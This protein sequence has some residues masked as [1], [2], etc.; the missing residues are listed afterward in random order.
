MNL[1]TLFNA[2]PQ[3]EILE[4][5]FRELFDETINTSFLSFLQSAIL[6]LQKE[7]SALSVTADTSAEEFRLKF[8]K[9]QARQFAFEELVSLIETIRQGAMK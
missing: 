5:V 9:L 1:T 4:T 8:A 7:R 2:H 3:K 6:A